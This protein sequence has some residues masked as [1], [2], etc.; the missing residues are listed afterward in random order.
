MKTKG[1]NRIQIFPSIIKQFY[2][3]NRYLERFLRDGKRG[4]LELSDDKLEQFKTLKKKVNDIG[5]DF[6][7]CLSEDLSHFWAEESELDGVP[8]DVIESMDVNDEG[9]RKVI[10]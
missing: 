7:K 5:I 3:C 9:Q 1:Y 4:G 10:S 6:R 8:Q 2:F